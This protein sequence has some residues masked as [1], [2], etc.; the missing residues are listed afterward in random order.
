[1]YQRRHER[2]RLQQQQ[3]TEYNFYMIYNQ[4]SS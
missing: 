2:K 4:I 3:H 1:M